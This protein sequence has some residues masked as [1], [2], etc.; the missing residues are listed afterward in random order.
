MISRRRACVDEAA[1][2]LART[3]IGVGGALAQRVDAAVDVGVVVLV[4][5]VD[6]LDHRARA[7]ARSGAVQVH[8][9]LAVDLLIEDRKVAADAGDV[10]VHAARRYGN[11]GS[12]HETIL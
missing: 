3:F 7:L 4:V 8:E 6:G 1:D 2:R 5:V 11:D 10:E 9:R 12:T